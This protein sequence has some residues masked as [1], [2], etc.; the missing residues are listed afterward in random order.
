MSN[1]SIKQMM[2]QFNFFTV[3]CFIPQKKLR[4]PQHMSKSLEGEVDTVV[5]MLISIY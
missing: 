3:I 5:S 2:Q 1:S 4:Q